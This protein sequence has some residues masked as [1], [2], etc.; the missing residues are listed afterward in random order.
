MI[1]FFMQAIISYFVSIFQL[2]ATLINI[3]E[4]MMNSF[5][6]GHGRTTQC[7]I[8]WV[9]L[10]KLSMHKVHEAWGL[11]T[12]LLSTWICRVNR[13]G[14]FSRNLIMCGVA[15]FRPSLLFV[16]VLLGVLVLTILFLF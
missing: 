1:K 2:P 6:W 16:E 10:D 5:W 14:I 12:S 8:N 15:S 3:I 4:K 13:V 9:S 11:R 7:G